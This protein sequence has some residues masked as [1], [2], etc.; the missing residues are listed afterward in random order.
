MEQHISDFMKLDDDFE[1]FIK[2]YVNTFVKWELV[3]FF[4]SNQ[5][6]TYTLNSLSRRLNRSSKTLKTEILE[7]VNKGLLIESENDDKTFRLVN[8]E[9]ENYKAV[10]ALMDR[11]VEFCKSREGRLR[12][13]YKILKDGKPMNS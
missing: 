3:Q 11:F 12:V 8:Q 9:T 7:L 4:H 5:N 13:I 1:L 6:Q 2:D 10:L